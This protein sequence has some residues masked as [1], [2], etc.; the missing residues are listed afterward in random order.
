[1]ISTAPLAPGEP[2]LA[3]TAM[4]APLPPVPAKPAVEYGQF[5][6][7][8]PDTYHVL[9][10]LP[11][12]TSAPGGTRPGAAVLDVVQQVITECMDAGLI[13][14]GDPLAVSLCL[15]ASLH[16][17]ITL[18]A[19]RPQVPWPGQDALIDTLLANMFCAE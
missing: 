1:M 15:W 7:D 12:A 14:S 6:A 18:R 9:F 4:F 17:L 3:P 10:G 8:H 13:R 19:A 2:A 5:A 16:G 11:G